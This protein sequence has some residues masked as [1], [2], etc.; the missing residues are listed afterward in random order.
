MV[1]LTGILLQLRNQFESV[2]PKAVS[3]TFQ[4]DAPLLTFEAISEKIGP[5][6]DQIIYKPKKNNLAVRMDDGR[7]IQLNSQTGE[8]LKDAPRRTSFLIE[9]HQGSWM[10]PFGQY[11]IH[12][13][14]G[15][16]LI[17]L[18]YSGFVIWK[19]GKF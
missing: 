13:L 18:I 12:L 14:S 15:I 2:Q 7:E 8:I 3:S 1:G 10:G 17:Y 19:K 4:K 5:G 9:L 6:V 16:G 11:F